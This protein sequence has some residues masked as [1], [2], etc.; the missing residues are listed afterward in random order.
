MKQQESIGSSLVERSWKPIFGM[1]VVVKLVVAAVMVLMV[2]AEGVVVT[3]MV[4][5]VVVEGVVV[6]VVA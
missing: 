5:M 2:V 6:A 3:V 1:L 4:L